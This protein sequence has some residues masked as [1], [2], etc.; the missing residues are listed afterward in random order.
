MNDDKYYQGFIKNFQNELISLGFL[1]SRTDYAVFEKIQK[2]RIKNN[3]ITIEKVTKQNVENIKKNL[4]KNLNFNN[5]QTYLLQYF[6]TDD[7]IFKE[8]I[9][10]IKSSFAFLNNKSFE[11]CINDKN[12][13]FRN[14]QINYD[15]LYRQYK[16]YLS[17]ETNKEY[18]FQK[19]LLE[20]DKF[21]KILLEKDYI[22]LKELEQIKCQKANLL[23]Y[24][25]KV[26]QKYNLFFIIIFINFL[27]I[28]TFMFFNSLYNDFKKK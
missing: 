10:L 25:E 15:N 24:D 23:F 7:A 27:I 5:E 28:V 18:E 12:S 2:W 6:N 20:F 16:K 13:K 8:K 17:L 19:N 1:T 21:L 26:L 14:L 22:K 9:N 3:I 4:N 11:K